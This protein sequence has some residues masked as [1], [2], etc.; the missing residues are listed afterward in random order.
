M[1]I[2][3][4]PPIQVA[5]SWRLDLTGRWDET[6]ALTKTRVKVALLLVVVVAG[7]HYSLSSLLQTVGFDTPL[8]YIG[9][10]PLLASALAW[11]RRRPRLGEPEIHDRQLD[12]ILGVP[13]V[14]GALVVAFVLPQHLGTIYWIDR[15]DLLSMPVFV[16]GVVALLF[17][18]RVLW[19][20][21]VAVLYLFLAWPWPYTTILLGALGGFT[22]VTVSALTE[23]LKIV[24][25]AQPVPGQANVGLF[26]IVHHGQAFPVSVVTACSGVD[27][28]VG[29]LLVGAGFSSLVAGP[30]LRKSIWLALGLVVLWSTNLLRL[31]LIF[32][33]GQR[34]GE[35]LALGILHP[36]AGLVIFCV[37]VLLMMAMLKPF[38]L[39]LVDLGPRPQSPSPDH[40]TVA[41]TGR[42]AVPRIFLAGS[43]V[44]VA[45]VFL[46]AN[47][48]TLR[49]FDPVASAVGVPKLTSFLA[50]PA[51]PPGWQPS[52]ET[53][54]TTNKPLFGQSSIWYRYAYGETVSHTTGELTSSVPVT[55]DVINGKGLSGF[56]QYGVVS[57]YS[58][59]G[60]QLR[61]VAKVSLGKGISGQ[62]L[63]YSATN[64]QGDWSIVYWIWPVKMAEGTRYERIIL[65]LQNTPNG[66]V[67]L[68]HDAPGITGLNHVRSVANPTDKRLILNRAF[69]VEFARQLIAAQTHQSEAT[70][71]LASVE[72]A[73][74]SIFGPGAQHEKYQPTAAAVAKR[75][76][77]ILRLEAQ[78]TLKNG[79]G[80]VFLAKGH[81]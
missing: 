63:S 10:V 6:T 62:A 8:A 81:R 24:P 36:V 71:T 15:I 3:T 35:H 31:L 25:I 34:W 13:L 50:D 17:G 80:G 55:A 39:R 23:V 74:Q 11:L 54:F 20:Q 51:S 47:N 33:V 70:A 53:E 48:S 40:G 73:H 5:R 29:F 14:A 69:L 16:A 22:N 65:Y 79:Y 37:G 68:P 56:E 42:L 49:S 72:S 59:H 46:A 57:C 9:L 21:R 4:L 61:D 28:M 27:G 7:Y 26:Q 41:A 1:T 30:L 75:R 67:V 44:A 2:A 43:L 12:Y 32:W 76:A 18:T 38:G 58:F 52:F 60:F 64:G 77:A 45:A 19:R 78:G 66:S